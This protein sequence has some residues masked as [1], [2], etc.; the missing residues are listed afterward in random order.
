MCDEFIETSLT[1]IVQVAGLELN[2]GHGVAYTQMTK[3][4]LKDKLYTGN[5]EFICMPLNITCM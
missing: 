4:Q 5:L 3:T 1:F 2:K